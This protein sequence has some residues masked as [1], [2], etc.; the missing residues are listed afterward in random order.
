MF[1]LSAVNFVNDSPCSD[2]F[3]FSRSF[4]HVN[5]QIDCAAV[6]TADGRAATFTWRKATATEHARSQSQ[7]E[8]MVPNL[9][10]VVQI[11]V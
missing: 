3:V 10:Y 11:H 6:A 1:C 2:G 9:V 8:I 4:E 5:V 7:R